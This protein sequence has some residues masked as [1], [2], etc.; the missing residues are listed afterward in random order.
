MS[1]SE[2]PPPQPQ[3]TRS[4]V[5]AAT[6][7]MALTLLVLINLFNY[8]DRQVIAAVEPEIRAELLPEEKKDGADGVD[9]AGDL[10]ESEYAKFWMG[11]LAT[12]F[13]IT[14]M[15]IAPLFGALADRYSR[16]GLVGFGVIVWS[17]ASGASGIEWVRFGCTLGTA[18]WLLFLTRCFVGVGEAAYGPVAP[19][20]IA[21]LYP[22]EKRGKIMAWFYLALPVGGALGYALG[23]IVKNLISWHW[24]F[25]CVVPPGIA[26]GVWCFLMREPRRGQAEIAVTQP[27]RKPSLSD[28]LFLLKIPSYTLNTLG[29][30]MMAFAIGGLAFWM[31][32]YLKQTNAPDIGPIGP[33]TFFGGV[34]A[35][36]GFVS[37]L[38]GGLTGD[39]L[40]PRIAGAYFIVSGVAMMLGFPMMLCML[41]TGYPEKWIFVFITVF[42]LFFNAGPTNTV[43]ANVIHPSMR[44]SAFAL[45]I[46][47]IHALGDAISPNVIGLVTGKQELDGGFILVSITMLIGGAIWLVGAK[48][49]QRDTELAPTRVPT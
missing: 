22:V 15:L 48:F 34:T 44:A 46:L 6:P 42:L 25:F 7:T 13:L 17:L 49:L 4:V 18:Y 26:L 14:Y 39:W 45:N 29:M 30:T 9:K 19:A 41:A 38:S 36:A 47:I 2:G 32:A 3:G 33:R 43:L 31:P 1:F 8:I 27:I 5:A 37:T 16:W 11:L 24:A 35:L 21:D 12:A 28:Y 20:M 40:R 23:E 10:E